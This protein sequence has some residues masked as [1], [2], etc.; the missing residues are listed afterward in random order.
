MIGLAVIGAIFIITSVTQM[1]TLSNY[2]WYVQVFGQ[3]YLPPTLIAIRYVGSCLQRILG[4]A[5][6]FGL[7]AR[8]RWAAQI[9]SIISAWSIITAYWKNPYAA[10]KNMFVLGDRVHGYGRIIAGFGWHHFEIT[11]LAWPTVVVLTIFNVLFFG[12]VFWYCNK[13]KIKTLLR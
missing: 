12:W 4:L 6:G 13:P 7:I 9:I 10:V 11:V 2:D 5:A 1:L 8:Y 3:Q